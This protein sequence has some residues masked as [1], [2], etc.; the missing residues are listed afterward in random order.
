MYK[1]W[2][3]SPVSDQFPVCAFRRGMCV[4]LIDDQD[5]VLCIGN[6]KFFYGEDKDI[7]SQR[8]TRRDVLLSE[9]ANGEYTML[10]ASLSNGV[11]VL[12]CFSSSRNRSL[13]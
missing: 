7:L 1:S 9:K 6:C 10:S 3:K 12:G 2:A 5:L 8:G 13:S 11:R 4:G